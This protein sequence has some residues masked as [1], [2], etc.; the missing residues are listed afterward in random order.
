MRPARVVARATAYLGRHGVDAPSSS[1]E[2]LMASVIGTDRSGVYVREAP[3]SPMQARTFGRRLCRR[4]TGTPLQHLTGEQ[5]FRRL[6]IR[7]RPGVFIP[8]PETEVVVEAA[9]AAIAGTQDPTVVDVGTGAGAIA[10]AIAQE[11]SDACVWATDVSSDAVALARENARRLELRVDVREGDLLAPVWEEL[12]GATDLVVSNPP[13]VRPDELDELPSDVR[14]DPVAAL[15]GGP[16]IYERLAH[17]AGVLLRHGGTLA[18]EIGE[19]QGAE[20]EAMFRASGFGEVAVHPDLAGRDRVV[21]AR[22]P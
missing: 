15:A 1:A 17:E 10:L 5:G 4:C 3:L 16:E 12:A 13:Y 20:I 11:R 2:L 22:S 18:V 21:V 9:L 6:L 8:R 14:L 7:V 19:T